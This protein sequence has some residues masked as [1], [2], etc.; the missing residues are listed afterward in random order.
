MPDNETKLRITSDVTGGVSGVNQFNTSLQKLKNDSAGAFSSIKTGWVNM[1]S[2]MYVAQQ[3]LNAFQGFTGVIKQTTEAAEKL[4]LLREKT[5]MSYETLKV[6]SYGAKL[7]GSDIDTLSKGFGILA[8]NMADTGTQFEGKT[9]Y[10]SA[11]GLSARDSSGHLKTMDQMIME[12][13][14]KFAVMNNGTAKTALSMQLFG[15][16]GKD[17]IPILNQGS[18]GVAEWKE[19]MIRLGFTFDEVANKQ[20]AAL[21]DQFDRLSMAGT[22]LKDRI[23]KEVVP[24]ILGGMDTFMDKIKEGGELDSTVKFAGY[25][26]RGLA[27]SA[28]GVGASFDLAG[29][30]IGESLA[31]F[32]EKGASGMFDKMMRAPWNVSMALDRFI[33]GD[34]G[35]A[36]SQDDKL[37]KMQEK[38]L[39][40]GKIINDLWNNTA[41][42]NLKTTAKGGLLG[43]DPDIPAAGIDKLSK[44][45]EQWK[46]RIASL[47]PFMDE[48]AKK[49]QSLKY[50]AS[51]L[52]KEFGDQS[53]ITKG[54]EQGKEYLAMTEQLKMVVHD[55]DETEFF[56]GHMEGPFTE[57]DRAIMRDYIIAMKDFEDEYS[58]ATERASNEMAVYYAQKNRTVVQ[59]M[60]DGYRELY[61]SQMTWGEAG[62]NF[63]KDSYRAMGEAWQDSIYDVIT[64]DLD[65][66]SDVWDATWKSMARSMANQLGT[67]LNNWIMFGSVTGSTNAGGYGGSSSG[68]GGLS[69]LASSAV[70]GLSD[71]SSS[72]GLWDSI[73]SGLGSAGEWVTSF[74]HEGGVVGVSSVPTRAINPAMFANAPRLHDGLLPDE[75]PAILQRGETVLPTGISI[76]GIIYP[77]YEAADYLGNAG[78]T[79]GAAMAQGAQS[80]SEAGTAF[81]SSV[82]K[83]GDTF[84]G[85]VFGIGGSI[86]GGMFGSSTGIPFGGQAGS[87]VGRYGG[88]WLGNAISDMIFGGSS[89]GSVSEEQALYGEEGW[90]RD[91]SN[92][93]ETMAEMAESGE[94]FVAAI[95]KATSSLT[96]SAYSGGSNLAGAYS[97]IANA[98]YGGNPAAAAD[99]AAALGLDLGSLLASN[100][101]GGA[102]YAN[103]YAPGGLFGA[104]TQAAANA[105]ANAGTMYG[106][107]YGDETNFHTG[108]V[109]MYDRPVVR[110]VDPAIFASAPRYPRGVGPGERA[111][112]IREDEGVFT[113]GQMKALGKGTQQKIEIPLYIDSREVGRAVFG[114]AANMRQLKVETGNYGRVL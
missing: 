77:I 12:T 36:A 25:I 49:F 41:P 88:T 18:A 71:S 30:L 22:N 27:A 113:P 95:E 39:A 56:S 8:K 57:E 33:F 40:Y 93:A 34:D 32:T 60:K 90:G 59:G 1:A 73:S 44:A 112:I 114:N 101:F 96:T 55:L 54:L 24:G 99:M 62:E 3:A 61:L 23:V 85:T 76:N 65:S 111:A 69:G 19:E 97:D 72:S 28:V 48:S 5:G 20:A 13:A 104:D 45:T 2:G 21:D 64:G 35:T 31:K 58:T 14:D 47:N 37:S 17:M 106:G 52:T 42:D 29:T 26:L 86:I 51:V 53:W 109:P 10:F 84:L 63:A 43:E 83:S 110:R 70:N 16:S 89:Y 67:M 79:A 38:A 91:F 4:E 68:W 108:G 100:A 7:A 11:L 78:I 82:S 98:Y 103:E 74:F 92:L 6:M 15:K 81:A 80:I 46:N 105:A 50:E 94:D 9:K 75:Y 66:L 87:L 107:S 102:S